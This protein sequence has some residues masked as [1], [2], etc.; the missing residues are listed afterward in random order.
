MHDPDLIVVTHEA[1]AAFRAICEIDRRVVALSGLL[2]HLVEGQ[3]LALEVAEA[4][5]RHDTRHPAPTWWAE[6]CIEQR[7]RP[8]AA[9]ADD[10]GG[11]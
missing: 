1:R 8:K 9:S 2:R 5:V 10:A 3:A 7:E 6:W 4:I 11:S